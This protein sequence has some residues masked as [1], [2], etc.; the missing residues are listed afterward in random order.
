MN[1]KARYE[2]PAPF[3]EAMYMC[4][5]KHMTTVK[6]HAQV[7]DF[8]KY[9][10]C[11]TCHQN[12]KYIASAGMPTNEVVPDPKKLSPEMVEKVEPEVEED[13]EFYDSFESD[14]DGFTN[15]HIQSLFER[16]SVAELE[17]LLESRLEA[18]RRGEQ[19]LQAKHPTSV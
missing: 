19:Y 4:D 7:K 13:F 1:H 10:D 3:T 9:W 11:T 16:R 6:F 18:F 8:P 15:T 12:A 5:N 17:A 2:K 14:T